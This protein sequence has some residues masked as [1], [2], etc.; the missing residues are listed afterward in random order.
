MKIQKNTGS[1]LML[2]VLTTLLLLCACSP[3]AP[4]KVSPDVMHRAAVLER[5]GYVTQYYEKG[6][7]TLSALS[8]EMAKSVDKD[9]KGAITGY[10]FVQDSTGQS[11]M[12]VFTFEKPEDAK[13]LYNH[14]KEKDTFVEGESECRID[15]TVVYMGYTKDL[16]KIE[17]T[18]N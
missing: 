1:S 10:L 11:V 5:E 18:V 7:A 13:L 14:L 4:E 15:H 6:N 2:L 16:D 3:T 8:E 17:G 9:L 12:E